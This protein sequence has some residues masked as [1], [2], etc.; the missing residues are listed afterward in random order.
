MKIVLTGA[1]GF[2]GCAIARYLIA[3]GHQLKLP[4]RRPQL[5]SRFGER[6]SCVPI[7]DM[8]GSIDWSSVL[9]GMEGLVHAAGLA[10]GKENDSRLFAVN[11]TATDK[12]MRAAARAGVGRIV[13][14]SSIRA[15]TG[16]HAELEI[17]EDADP[18]PIE[19][20][21]RSKLLSEAAVLDAGVNGVILRPPLIYGAGVGTNMRLLAHLARSPLPLPFGGLRAKRSIVSDVNLASAAAHVLQLSNTKTFTALVADAE[22]V[23][24]RE[25]VTIFREALG[26]RPM[27]LPTPDIIAKLVSFAGY[28]EVWNSLARPLRLAP[29]RLADTGWQPP[30]ASRVAL[31]RVVVS[32]AADRFRPFFKG[33]ND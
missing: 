10:H 16:R 21:G 31:R 19:A 9:E 33:Q 3:D 7:G 12:L 1:T 6:A 11:V 27:L 8:A 22:P 24:V 14:I 4:M 2:V 5:A 28:E 20:Y 29:R 30:E 13:H 23:S 26:R 17:E 15:V 25:M 32:P 18:N